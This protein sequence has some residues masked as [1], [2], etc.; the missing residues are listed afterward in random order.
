MTRLAVELREDM[1]QA[2]QH[3]FDRILRS[4][5]R[6][7][8]PY[9]VLLNSPD[10]AE[11]VSRV[12]DSIL[13]ESTLAPHVKYLAMMLAARAFR[14]EYVWDA[15]LPHAL[16]AGVPRHLADAIKHDEVAGELTAEQALVVRFCGKLLAGNHHLDDDTYRA[17]VEQFGAPAT[18][19]LS[20]TVGHTVMMSMLANAFEVL[21]DA[22]EDEPVL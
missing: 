4:R 5:G 1:P 20:Y 17:V 14:C 19:Q 2:D 21:V 10:L 6:V 15:V 13:Y 18:A 9:A 7:S 22:D 8:G 12:G 3:F 16:R 11:R